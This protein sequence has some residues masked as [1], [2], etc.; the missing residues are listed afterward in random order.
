M[1]TNRF[2]LAAAAL[3]LMATSCTTLQVATD[4]NP[5][6][7]FG[8]LKSY[9]WLPHESPPGSDVR[10]NNALVNDR[11][12]AAV[13]AQLAE[14]GYHIAD[15][16]PDFYV[17]WLGAIDRKMRI[18][19][20]NDFYGPYWHGSY[21]CC[22]PYSVRTYISEYDE[23]TLIIDVL[24]AADHKLVWRGSGKDYISESSSPEE[25]IRKTN[26]VVSVILSEFPPGAQDSR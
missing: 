17:T 15:S 4:F 16:M 18:D 26:E 11:V 5:E 14:K 7:D 6:F 20:I 13:D 23:G 8:S 24:N 9:A 10:I 12:V 21:G 2:H 19:T 22:L 1:I 3:V 25:T